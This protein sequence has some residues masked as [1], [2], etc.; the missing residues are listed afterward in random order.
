MICR[1][2]KNSAQCFAV[3]LFVHLA[4]LQSTF[5][6]DRFKKD[7]EEW[8]RVRERLRS[9]SSQVNEDDTY[10]N[11]YVAE[12]HEILIESK[13]VVVGEPLGEGAFGKV[14]RGEW[15]NKTT[16][17]V[18]SVHGPIMFLDGVGCIWLCV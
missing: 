10:E 2:G 11:P 6:K 15:R 12:P 7:S 8:E 18:V 1:S 13:Y 17:A 3:I 14:F 5:K 4:Y 16:G 9:T